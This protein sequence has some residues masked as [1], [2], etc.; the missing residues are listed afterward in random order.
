MSLVLA[1]LALRATG[2]VISW[3]SS[4]LLLST[5][6]IGLGLGAAFSPT[7]RRGHALAGIGLGLLATL[8]GLAVGAFFGAA[9]GL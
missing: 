5:L 2:A 8:C 3:L 1:G 7:Q 4:A 6:A 9:R